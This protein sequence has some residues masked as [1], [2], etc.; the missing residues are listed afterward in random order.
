MINKKEWY[1]KQLRITQTVLREPDIVGYDPEDVVRYL[2]EVRSNCIVINGGGIVDFFH[3]DLPL[4]NPN[5][6]MTNEDILKDL[7][8]A[9][10]RNDIKV[11]V[12]VDFRGVDKRIYDLRPDWFGLNEAGEP[13][14]YT[15]SMPQYSPL[16]APCYQS[17]YRNEHAFEFVRL[18]LNRYKI[19]GIWENSL[20]QKGICYCQHCESKYQ[21][22]R[23][24][25]LPRG[26][27]FY[28]SVYDEY[29]SW[30]AECVYEHLQSF[31]SVV[32]E[33]GEDKAFCAEIFG[34]FYDHYQISGHDL[35]SIR[36]HFDFLVTPLFAG[37][38]LPSTAPSTLIKFMKSL[39]PD[40]T[41]VMLFGHLGFNNQL[42][43]VSSP[44][45]ESRLWLFQA[46]S[47]G[48]SFW[49]T[50]FNGMH[51]GKTYDRRNAM[52]CQDMYSFMEENEDKLS[53]QMPMAEVEV[54]YSRDSN[55]QFGRDDKT[56]DFYLTHVMGMEQ[57]LQDQHIQYSIRTDDKL[58]LEALGATKVLIVPNALC[59][60][61]E[62][63]ETIRQFVSQG[64]SLLTTHQT[65]L[66]YPDGTKRT[67]FALR[68]V[69]G[70]TNTGVIQNVSG[71][72]YQ[73]IRDINHPLTKGFK[74]TELIA[75]WGSNVL[76]R[77]IFGD[78][79]EVPITFV[80]KILPQPPERSWP[81]SFETDYPTVIM[82]NF[83]KGKVIFFPYEVDR[84]VYIHG[85]ADFTT[86]LKNA[87]DHLLSEKRTIRTNAPYSVNISLNRHCTRPG[88]FL[89]HA[90]NTTSAPR[91]PVH[92]IVP[93]NGLKIAITVPGTD[94]KDIRSLYKQTNCHY[95]GSNPSE[96]GITIELEIP[97]LKEYASVW[98]E[99]NI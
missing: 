99:V 59:M 98:L 95:V 84:N 96:D 79:S 70:C 9:C 41:P 71:S 94:V 46:A 1:E 3:H 50:T 25:P 23:N 34:L 56:E 80:P 93:I 62:Q 24:K 12:R 5:P 75:G 68:D 74:D 35:Y 65:S 48:G 20:D 22:D 81:K 86:L 15:P 10:H 36:E 97:L 37:N 18:L 17:P 39:S 91:R 63:A 85:H 4:A 89:L 30:K 67:D 53:D 66:Y 82:R 78:K 77:P 61:D 29:R 73:L 40:K 33:Y 51:P 11:I 90:V 83:G 88:C 60:S 44:Y 72:G 54:L 76:V 49:N 32:K 7:T 21:K 45:E 27:N 42:R 47:A 64:G 14:L 19:D 92:G 16:Y 52:L 38:R 58:K 69:F 87:V 2:K 57:V 31:R 6:F 28:T 13:L 55:V 8:E 43:Y 26:E